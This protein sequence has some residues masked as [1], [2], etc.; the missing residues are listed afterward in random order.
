MYFAGAFILVVEPS[1]LL[2]CRVSISRSSKNSRSAPSNI[3]CQALLDCCS[4]QDYSVSY[5]ESDLHYW[6]SSDVSAVIGRLSLL[7]TPDVGGMHLSQGGCWRSSLHRQF[8][9]YRMF[10]FQ[11]G[12]LPHNKFREFYTSVPPFSAFEALW[13]SLQ[14]KILGPVFFLLGV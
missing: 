7:F 14:V 11:L 5:F 13:T 3:F 12:L 8:H 1:L 6:I 2:F 4:H 9:Q 10:S